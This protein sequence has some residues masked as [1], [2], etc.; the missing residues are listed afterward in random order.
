MDDIQVSVI[1]NA[2]NHEKYI[3][4][5]MEGFVMQKTTFP[6]EILVHDDASTDKTADIIRE[7]ENKY[8]EIVK[9]IYETVNQYSKRDGSL[10][11]IQHGRVRGRYIAI[12]EGDDYWTDPFKLQKQFEALEANPGVDICASGTKNEI[13]GKIQDKVFPSD[14]DALFTPDEV[15]RGG[16]GFVATGSLMYRKEVR[17][18]PLP[19]FTSI[20]LDY[21]LQIAASLRGG[22][23]YL[24]EPM[25]IFRAET[26][27]S[28]TVRMNQNAGARKKHN[29]R[30]CAMLRQ[31][32]E[33]TAGKYH[34]AV[35][36]AIHNLEFEYL[37]QARDYKVI[38][39]S[40][41]SVQFQKMPVYRQT[42]MRIGKYCPWVAS[43]IFDLRRRMK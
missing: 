7:Y 37:V 3:R 9:P 36:E 42:V 5:A 10:H 23:L 25:S 41:Y 13:N 43:A 22:M 4:D 21:A 20:R 32:D 16:G 8:P 26:E 6:F 15:I 24:G 31:L 17:E 1:C 27:G 29:D 39:A 18:N 2:Y 40:E 19:F 12:C 28:W 30:V 33:D 14:E 34:D 38:C 35:Q 11:R